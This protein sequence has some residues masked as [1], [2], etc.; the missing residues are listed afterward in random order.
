MAN[1]FSL[2][3][4]CGHIHIYDAVL[5]AVALQRRRRRLG[6]GGKQAVAQDSLVY[7]LG[8]GALSAVLERFVP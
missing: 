6:Q 1:Q 3:N 4:Q 2:E 5:P 7:F 8:F